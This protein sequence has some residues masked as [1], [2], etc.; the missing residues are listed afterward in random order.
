MV[1]WKMELFS[2]LFHQND[3]AFWRKCTDFINRQDNAN[4]RKNL[5]AIQLSIWIWLNLQVS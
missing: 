1:G 4:V 3:V 5:K 2:Y